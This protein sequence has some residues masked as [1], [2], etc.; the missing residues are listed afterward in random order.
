MKCK[1]G[2]ECVLRDGVFH[3]R[4]ESFSGWVCECNALYENKED[5]MFKFIKGK[6]MMDYSKIVPPPHTTCDR[7]YGESLGIY[8]EGDMIFNW[9]EGCTQIY[10]KG[11]W[12]ELQIFVLGRN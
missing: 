4:G 12:E 3:L 11:K 1:C 6:K 8:K 10:I 2:K 9:D 7:S 5:S